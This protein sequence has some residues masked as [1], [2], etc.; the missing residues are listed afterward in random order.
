LYLETHAVDTPQQV[1]DALFA[2]ATPSRLLF[3]SC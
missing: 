1:R 2:N 3:E